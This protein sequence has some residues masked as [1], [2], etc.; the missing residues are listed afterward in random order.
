MIVLRIIDLIGTPNAILHRFGLQVFNAITSHLENGE[1]VT[2]SFEGVK[3]CTT[4][5]CHAAI[6]KLYLKFPGK[7]LKN[8]FQIAGIG[9][10]PIWEEIIDE[11]IELALHP[12]KQELQNEIV[13]N[14][15]QS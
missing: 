3:N 1:K 10:N 11:C 9:G 15:L 4:A 2:L 8:K 14:L 5:F 7:L 6:G 13:E 12:E